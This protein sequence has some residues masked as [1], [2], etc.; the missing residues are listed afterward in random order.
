M[1]NQAYSLVVSD[2]SLTFLMRAENDYIVSCREFFLTVNFHTASITHEEMNLFSDDSL[3]CLALIPTQQDGTLPSRHYCLMGVTGPKQLTDVDII[4]ASRWVIRNLIKNN[5]ERWNFQH[6]LSSR[7][8]ELLRLPNSTRPAA[9]VAPFIRPL[10]FSRL[11]EGR[12]W[13]P[14]NLV[15]V[16]A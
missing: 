10:M 13:C 8:D 11:V 1:T 6:R 16:G 12:L 2:R 5:P 9:A 3:I 4:R 15:E 14:E 7:L